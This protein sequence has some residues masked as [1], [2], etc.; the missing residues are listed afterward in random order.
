M[1]CCSQTRVRYKQV[2][3]DG[4][5]FFLDEETGEV[6]KNAPREPWYEEF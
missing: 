2:W 4:E 1:P 5:D 3:Q 6:Q